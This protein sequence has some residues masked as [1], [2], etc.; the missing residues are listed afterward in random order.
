MGIL[1]SKVKHKVWKIM[2]IKSVG[3]HGYHSTILSGKSYTVHSLVALT[4]LG[5]SNGRHINHKN[6]IKTDNRIENLEYVT[7][8]QNNKHAIL[9][10]LINNKGECHGR[11]RVSNI[12]ALVIR[13]AIR[14]G[15]RQSNVARYFKIPRQTVN[16]IIKGRAFKYLP[17]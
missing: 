12:Q 2:S 16:G 9:N 17:I 13:E 7:Q 8:S 4:F 3:S 15:H 10:G 11:A 14:I 6:G 1:M 5:P